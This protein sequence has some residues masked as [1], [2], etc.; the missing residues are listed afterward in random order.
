LFEVGDQIVAARVDP[1]VH[2]ALLAAQ[3]AI[4]GVHAHR[5]QWI[6]LCTLSRSGT[7]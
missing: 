2:G 7:G 6:R 3:Q 5:H 4:D 1:H